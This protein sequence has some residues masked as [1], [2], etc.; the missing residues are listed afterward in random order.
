[1]ILRLART[2]APGTG[3]QP[4]TEQITGRGWFAMPCRGRLAFPGHREP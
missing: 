4:L 3:D 2:T 1:M